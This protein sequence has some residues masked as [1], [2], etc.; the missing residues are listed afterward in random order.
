MKI[1]YVCQYFP[2]EMGAPAARASELARHW[3]TMGHQVTVLTGFPN[4]PTGVLHPEYRNKFR[5]LVCRERFDG[6]SVVRTWLAPLPNRKALERIVNYSSFCASAS[7]TGTLVKKPDVVIATSP[8]L[9]VGL[10]GWWIATAK[11]VPFIFEVR[12]L[13]PESLQA[14]GVSSDRSLLNRSLGA[15]AGFLYR[16]SSHIVVVTPAFKDH[17]ISKWRLPEAKISVVENGVDTELFSPE[18]DRSAVRK[19]LG[20]ENKFVAAYVGTFGNAHGLNTVLDA[21]HKLRSANPEIAFLMVGEGAEKEKIV[22]EA[23]RRELSNVHFLSQQPR[24]RIPE[25]IRAADASLV[26]LKKSDVFKT[27]IPTKMLEFMACG[28]PVILGVE[29]QARQ[30]LGDANAGVFITPESASE[31]AEALVQLSRS[32]ETRGQLGAN[33]RRYAGEKLSREQTARKYTELLDALLR[34]NSNAP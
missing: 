29:G 28:S 34:T 6:A 8:Q 30:I 26:L 2:P 9:L 4:H 7:V 15:V 16:H 1:L 32:P 22:K 18:G 24:E 33:G 3:S 17:L 19:Q 5:R 23:E 27:V 14:V 31:L 21:A 25:V 11:R 10:S 12:D 20:L 13:W